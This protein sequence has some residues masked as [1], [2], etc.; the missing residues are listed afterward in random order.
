MKPRHHVYLDE[1]LSAQLEALASR[2]GGSKSA[3]VADALRAYFLHRGAREIDDLLKARL[4][5]I[6]NQLGRI[7]R[8]GHIG[9]ESLALFIRYQL[10]VT[11]PLA[12]SDR[13]GRALGRDRFQLLVNEV[14]RRLSGGRRTLDPTSPEDGS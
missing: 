14:G 1:A 6:S 10:N 11:P 12:E 13:V 2:P 3:I 9:L 8:D 7:E 5:R 4:D